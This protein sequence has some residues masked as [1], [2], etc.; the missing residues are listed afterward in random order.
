MDTCPSL[1]QFPPLPALPLE[2]V[3]E[4]G[5]PTLMP[6]IP[7]LI[8]FIPDADAKDDEEFELVMS[9]RSPP[10][11]PPPVPPGAGGAGREGVKDAPFQLMARCAGASARYGT[12][13]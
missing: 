9:G 5:E 12:R 4:A 8:P 1:I 3:D 10:L 2:Y 7:R 11:P 6:P 13:V